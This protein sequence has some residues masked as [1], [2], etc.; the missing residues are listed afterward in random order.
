MS[1]VPLCPFGQGEDGRD[2]VSTDLQHLFPVARLFLTVLGMQLMCLSV[3]GKYPA[4]KL[5]PQCIVVM[6]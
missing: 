2:A 1:A 3:P 5:H 6:A 4:T